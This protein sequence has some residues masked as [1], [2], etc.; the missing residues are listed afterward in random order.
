MLENIVKYCILYAMNIIDIVQSQ[1]T[2]ISPQVSPRCFPHMFPSVYGYYV[3]LKEIIS[4]SLVVR[5]YDAQ[6][7]LPF[8]LQHTASI[9]HGLES[10]GIPFIIEGMEY[11]KQKPCVIVANHM[12]SL[13]TIITALFAAGCYP[14]S[15]VSKRSVMSYP[16]FK[17][18]FS[19]LYPLL[20]DRNNPREDFKTVLK[21][22]EKILQLGRHVVIFPQGTRSQTCIPEDFSSIGV[23]LA[24]TA[25]RSVI[26]LALKTDAWHVGSW[27]KDIGYIQRVPVRYKFFPPIEVKSATGKEEH[28]ECVDQIC[29]T[30]SRWIQEDNSQ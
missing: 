23:K 6:Q 17:E 21:E 9:V 5:K 4:C 18:I 27:I 13:E 19:K 26:P 28:M 20:I 7:A 16:F 15:F 2:Y 8:I 24:K 30:V 22:G 14:V 1:D 11:T 25:N 3:L 29:M 10:I 12:S